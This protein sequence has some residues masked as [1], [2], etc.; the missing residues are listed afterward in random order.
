ML[1]SV[2]QLENE[3]N[4]LES[5]CDTLQKL[6]GKLNTKKMIYLNNVGFLHYIY[7]F[8]YYFKLYLLYVCVKITVA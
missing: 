3:N 1:A 2:R 8:E 6:I 4:L 7:V 5:D